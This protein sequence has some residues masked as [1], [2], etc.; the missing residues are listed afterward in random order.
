MIETKNKTEIDFRLSQ[1]GDDLMLGFIKEGHIS[2]V[3]L[4]KI[5]PNEILKYERLEVSKDKKNIYH[6]KVRYN[7]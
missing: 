5:R 4:Q 2:T 1:K 3:N 6:F 7:K